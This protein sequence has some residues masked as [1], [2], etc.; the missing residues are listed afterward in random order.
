MKLRRIAYGALAAIGALLLAGVLYLAFGDLSRHKASLESLASEALGRPFAIDGAFELK[1]LP[2]I[3]VVA[4]RVR[5]GNAPWGAAP[6]MVEIG[7]FSTEIRLWSLLFGPVDVRSLELRDVSV[8]LERNA[9]GEGNWVLGRAHEAREAEREPGE[10]VTEVPAVVLQAR[11]EHVNVS[12]RE[13]GKPSRSARLDTATIGLGP[14]ER[15]A[16]SGKGT[17]DAHPFTVKAEVGP[18]SAL[19]AGRDLRLS[20]D[21][22]LDQLEAHLDGTLGRLDPLAG[23]DLTLKVAHPDVAAL[24]KSLQQP[25]FAAGPLVVQ[26]RLTGGDTQ[27]ARLDLDAK[28]GDLSLKGEGALRT[29][30]LAG[31]N[32]KFDASVADAARVA[33]A[34]GVDGLGAGALTAAGRIAAAPEEIKLEGVSAEF[35]GA[36]ATVDG[37]LRASRADLHF[38][39]VARDLAALRSGLPAAPLSLGGAVAADGQRLE[40]KDAKGRFAKSEFTLE[41]AMQGGGSHHVDAALTSPSID[42]NPLLERKPAQAKPARK[43]KAKYV[44]TEAPLPLDALKDVDARAHVAIGELRIAAGSLKD[45]DAVLSAS[46]GKASLEVRARGGVSG[47]L[48]GSVKLSPAGGRQAELAVELAAKALRLGLGAGGPIAPGEVPA[49][50]AQVR[51]EAKGAS[52][53]ELASGANGKIH[54]AAGPGKVRSGLTAVVG[55]D[56]LG[57]LVGKLNPFAAQDPYTQLDCGVIRGEIADGQAKLEPMFMQTKKVAVVAA[58]QIDL[59][60]EALAVDFNTRPRTGIGISAGMFATPF[61][62]VA[63]TLASPRL[64]VG[65]KGA[66]AGAAAAM[67]GGMTVLA[68]GLLDRARGEQD[69]CKDEKSP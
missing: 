34:F 40:L 7:H 42:L 55:G 49:T 36:K 18:V 31:A 38:D 39:F 26:A 6:Q 30:G 67:T 5:V 53:R 11:L 44:F 2:S 25:A 9:A 15:L 13:A 12:Y 41:L 22:S 14:D 56:L 66:A 57:E 29:L 10:G 64:G 61:I 47:S 54:V 43:P 23:A 35:A 51:L 33:K 3:A 63:G 1:V 32:L 48:A 68:Q 37:T 20:A 46:G 4:D 69:L 28:A 52:A 19:F 17:V 58:G 59:Q 8:S 62:E 24:L 27:P 45:L 60:T 50:S 65:A 21:A 16:M